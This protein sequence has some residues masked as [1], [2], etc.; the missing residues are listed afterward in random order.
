VVSTIAYKQLD[1]I[2]YFKVD[3]NYDAFKRKVT[4]LFNKRNEVLMQYANQGDLVAKMF[5]TDVWYKK[6]NDIR[7]YR[8]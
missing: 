5:S 3:S 1:G 6:M 8:K 7:N 2:K 4:V